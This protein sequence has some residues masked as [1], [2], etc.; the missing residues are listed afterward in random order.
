MRRPDPSTET[1]MSSFVVR[2]RAEASQTLFWDSLNHYPPTWSSSLKL[3]DAL[4]KA[5]EVPGLNPSIAQFLRIRA[6]ELIDIKNPY[7]FFEGDI[8]WIN[9]QGDWDLTLGYYEEYHSPWQ[10]TAIMEAFLGVIDHEQ[11]KK[12]LAFRELLYWMEDEIERSLGQT[13]QRRNFKTLP[14]LRFARTLSVGDAR[15]RFVTLAFYLPNIKPYGR[16]DLSKKVI[17]INK[18]LARFEGVIRPLA[19]LTIDPAQFQRLSPNDI[20]LFIISHENA[21]GAGPGR[22]YQ[23]K[24]RDGG[25]TTVHTLLG[26]HSSSL[27]EARAD[28]LGLAS[29]PEAVRRGMI[30]QE[31]G[32]N[33]ASGLL[34]F[35]IRGL[36]LGEEDDHGKASY[37]VFTSLLE[38]GGIVETPEG[39]YAVNLSGGKIFQLAEELA[40]KM[41]RIQ[42]TA[43]LKGYKKWYERSKKSLPKKMREEHLPRLNKMPKDFFPYY[44]FKFSEGI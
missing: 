27:E 38:K 15:A 14:P 26:A 13:Y 3:A 35:L 28:L 43:D 16:R 25:E 6:G 12:G 9:L 40:Q 44:R 41:N 17:L 31:Q 36:A 22:S 8:A 7:P 30:K 5:S 10:L 23:I 11:E 2:R 24:T 29:L 32:E 18:M 21:H 37:V 4:L 20:S 39:R 1:L 34:A 33:A 19:E 42:V